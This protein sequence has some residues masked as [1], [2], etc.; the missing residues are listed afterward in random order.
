MKIS[1]II[2][3]YNTEKYI[4]RCIDSCLNQTFS[5]F[6]IIIINDGSNDGSKGI[7][8]SYAQKYDFIKVYTTENR[9]LS[10]ARNLGMDYAKGKYIY[11]LDSDD[12]IDAD[13]LEKC[14][15]YA[16]KYELEIVAFDAKVILEEDANVKYKYNSY[17][18]RGKA[19]EYTLQT[20]YEFIKDY[21]TIPVSAPAWEVLTQKEFLTKNNIRFLEGAY[22]EDNKFHYDSM[23]CA[24]RVMYIPHLFYNRTYR[25]DSIMTSK[26]NVKKLES[27]FAISHGILDTFERYQGKHKEIWQDYAYHFLPPLFSTAIEEINYSNCEVLI[28]EWNNMAKNIIV[29]FQR[30]LRMTGKKEQ[31]KL[32][33]YSTCF[34]IVL[35]LYKKTG[36]VPTEVRE[37]VLDISNSCQQVVAKRL[38]QLPFDKDGS[39]VGIY[40]AGKHSEVLLNYYQRH[41]G[42]IKCKL[43]F[44]D[45]NKASYTEKKFGIDIVNVKDVL[46]E[47]IDEMVIS[48]Y[49]YEQDMYAKA[50]DVV[51]NQMS[52]YKLYEDI[53]IPLE[54]LIN[55]MECVENIPSS[56]QESKRIVL[57]NIPEHTNVG[58]YMITLAEE[59]LIRKYFPTYEILEF[60]GVDYAKNR[61][62]IV[63]QIRI[64]DI[65]CITGGGFLGNLWFSS[66]NVNKILND[67]RY[68]KIV[69]FP[70][71]VYFKEDD[72]KEKAIIELHKCL[73]HCV[74]VTV[75]LRERHSYEFMKAVYK[76]D[77]K[78]YL[79]PD[80]VLNL[81]Y[82]AEKMDR[83]G[84]LLCL[85]NDVES[86]LSID[87][88]AMIKN[89]AQEISDVIKET[90]MHWSCVIDNDAKE[91]IINKKITEFKSAKLVITDTLHCMISCAISGTPC[92]A[93]NNLTGKVQGVYEW[94][95]H[96]EY[97]RYCDT[98][99]DVLKM[100]LAEWDAL[101]EDWKYNSVFSP[102]ERQLMDFM[103]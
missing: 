89:K 32:L 66:N 74:D 68:N 95:K 87:E 24:S 6:E 43:V 12:W 50:K 93:L 90:S 16:E 67:F 99:E 40:G 101:K 54:I 78:L 29:L 39:I 31:E 73:V 14:Y 2:P 83:D 53:N 8:L 59:K 36:Y 98:V 69:V 94:V 91:D 71:T 28:V 85:R 3:L 20:G 65:I 76:D 52:I 64:T 49:L 88:K 46:K 42:E 82:S 7:V 9:G 51:G 63:N 96:L 45:T 86:L 35:S 4:S 79:M 15:Y 23:I 75:C 48:S 77:V 11:F 100:D 5:D 1:I 22:Y 44:V 84:V 25:M 10:A 55:T 13:C 33:T 18:R 70:Q 30:L 19:K 27:A 103:K 57:L 17:D 81:N 21:K 72:H 92:I 56:F 41:V 34:Q 62:K 61:E 102:Y 58:D 60:S 80:I 97:I 38:S 37:V 26:Y 47:K